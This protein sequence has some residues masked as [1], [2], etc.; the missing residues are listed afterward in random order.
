M[1][2]IATL[3]LLALTSN[4]W[5]GIQSVP[6]PDVFSLFAV[7]AVGGLALWLRNRNRK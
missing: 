5:A 2:R 3:F 6:E 4:A 1:K 7:G